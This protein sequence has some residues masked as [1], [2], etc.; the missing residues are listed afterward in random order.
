MG[1]KIPKGY[2]RVTEIIRAVAPDPE[3]EAGIARRPEVMENA[4]R[5]GR[6]LH[7]VAGYLFS[8]KDV[9]LGMLSACEMIDQKSFDWILR[10]K[11]FIDLSRWKLANKAFRMNNKNEM[12]S[13]ELDFVFGAS[14]NDLLLVDLKC[15]EKI[16]STIKAQLGGY[17]WLYQK[18]KRVGCLHAPIGRR[19]KYVEYD[20]GECIEEWI[21]ILMKFKKTGGSK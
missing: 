5:R 10:M 6:A 9:P 21:M 14:K 19:P 12:V 16:P 3:I 11:D 13:G 18:N 2:S 8:R 20:V 15:T 17:S 1:N 7:E 4:A